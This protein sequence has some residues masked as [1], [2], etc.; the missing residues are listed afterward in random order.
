[1]LPPFLPLRYKRV[2]QVRTF[3]FFPPSETSSCPFEKELS[4]PLPKKVKKSFLPP[5]LPTILGPL[6]V[7][8][9]SSFPH[10]QSD[11][12]PRI[13]PL[14]FLSFCSRKDSLGPPRND[15]GFFSLPS[16]F[17]RR[18]MRAPLFHKNRWRKFWC[19]FPPLSGIPVF[20]SSDR[21]PK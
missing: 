20:F 4:P 5:P 11:S 1:M 16:P 3:P 18:R 15:D 17:L 6:F 7:H 13:P 8:K 12:I 10:F 2:S 21:R 9:A 14:T 19:L